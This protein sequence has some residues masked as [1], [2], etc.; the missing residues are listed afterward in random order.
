MCVIVRLLRRELP[1]LGVVATLCAACAVFAEDAASAVAPRPE[2]SQLLPLPSTAPWLGFGKLALSAAEPARLEAYLSAAKGRL[3]EKSAAAAPLLE[4]V[5]QAEASLAPARSAL[6]TAQQ[7]AATL[8]KKIEA[9]QV[10]I[11]QTTEARNRHEAERTTLAASIAQI[12]EAR[13]LVAE[14]LRHLTEA[15]GK[16][17]GDAAL[18]ES[19]RQLTEKLK[20]ME[21][22]AAEL[23]AKAAELA[24][25][26][27]A[28][29]AKL[30][31]TTAQREAAVKEAAAAAARVAR[32]QSEADKLA[33]A[34][35]A[36]R[37]AAQPA[38]AA[39][40]AAQQEVERWQN[41]IAFRDR[42]A[43]LAAELTSALQMAG[44]RE[45]TLA[46]AAAELA[47]AQSA[48]EAATAQRDEAAQRIRAIRAKIEAAR[49]PRESQGADAAT[50]AER[51]VSGSL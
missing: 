15:V 10:E 11:Q 46:S 32:L 19:Q 8:Q 36:A 49:T 4:A 9:L 23:G 17:P 14:A 25:T 28:A 5:R 34:V 18:A 50:G 13:P 44:E 39:V 43:A 12:Q 41:E 31:E 1:L 35:A 26:I 40:A 22:Q 21:T 7:D 6:A 47:A 45:A 20:A 48:V 51:G 37:Q 3:E 16:A 24:T 42:M 38:E 33:A 2:P 30:K 29:D 27:A